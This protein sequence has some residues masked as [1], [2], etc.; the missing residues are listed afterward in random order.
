M[1][2]QLILI[3]VNILFCQQLDG[4]VVVAF[5]VHLEHTGVE[6]GTE[7]VKS[8]RLGVLCYQEVC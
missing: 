8:L 5:D 3:K 6:H 7:A 2:I 1:F 4:H